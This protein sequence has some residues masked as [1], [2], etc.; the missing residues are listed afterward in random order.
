[1]KSPQKPPPDKSWVKRFFEKRGIPIA[2]PDH[3]IYS[4]GASVTFIP[5]KPR[6]KNA[7]KN[8]Q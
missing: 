6:L 5:H 8:K 1:M 2:P 7:K 4:E 3:W